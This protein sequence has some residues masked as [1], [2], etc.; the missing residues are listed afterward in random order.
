MV[1]CLRN[2]LGIGVRFETR[3]DQLEVGARSLPIVIATANEGKNYVPANSV[4][5]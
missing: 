5:H 1:Q 3:E 2:Y 4:A